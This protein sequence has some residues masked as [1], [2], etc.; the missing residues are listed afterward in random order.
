MSHLIPD[1]ALKSH[2]VTLETNYYYITEAK[3]Y[4]YNTDGGD[5]K[6]TW[7]SDITTQEG[8]KDARVH[9]TNPKVSGNIIYSSS[10][11]AITLLDEVDTL[12]NLAG[13]QELTNKVLNASLLKG[14]IETETAVGGRKVYIEPDNMQIFINSDILPSVNPGLGLYVD[15]KNI[16]FNTATD[17]NGFNIFGT[18]QNFKR[19][20]NLGAAYNCVGT[21]YSGPLTHKDLNY[22]TGYNLNYESPAGQT[23]H[24]KFHIS[25]INYDATPVAADTWQYPDDGWINRRITIWNDL[26]GIGTETPTESLT[27]NGNIL[28]NNHVSFGTSGNI[29]TNVVENLEETYTTS[30]TNS[31]QTIRVTNNPAASALHD[32]RGMDGFVVTTS[33]NY[34][35]GSQLRG[36]LYGCYGTNGNGSVNL[37]AT[38]IAC[39]VYS[40]TAQTATYENIVGGEFFTARGLLGVAGTINA[41]ESK[42]CYLNT[43]DDCN[44]I[45]VTDSY[46]LYIDD[47]DSGSTLNYSIYTNAGSIRLGGPVENL[48]CA[49]KPTT[50]SATGPITTANHLVLGDST[51][52]N[53]TITLP[54]TTAQIGKEFIFVKTVAANQVIITCAGADSFDF[55]ATTSITLNAIG[56]RA[57][58]ISSIAGEWST[59]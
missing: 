55:T 40:V 1:S 23:V 53:V 17:A 47:I 4:T 32:Q 8:G 6:I 44:T 21:C 3:G 49:Y 24:G 15:N 43:D 31:G 13:T 35:A 56:E 22:A 19:L 34:N 36:L 45:N 12:V 14:V 52:G 27:V 30:G 10:D 9:V 58:I 37:T 11:N 48:H 29:L 46:G 51:V 18:N 25:S 54:L 41:T 38:G 50:I 42:I 26:V 7:D 59:F 5:H 28:N 20:I 39:G 57:R 33:T 2:D 16:Q